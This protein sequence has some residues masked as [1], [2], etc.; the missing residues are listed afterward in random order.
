[1]WM[2]SPL[3]SLKM[4][5]T[6]RLRIATDILMKG[7]DEF[8]RKFDDIKPELDRRV[9]QEMKFQEIIGLQRVAEENQLLLIEARPLQSMEE[10]CAIEK[11]IAD[12]KA[13]IQ[14]LKRHESESC[15]RW[16]ALGEFDGA[17]VSMLQQIQALVSVLR[18][19]LNKKKSESMFVFSA[20]GM[21]GRLP[22]IYA[23]KGDRKCQQ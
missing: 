4:S 7:H 18:I 15:H 23:S 16:N 5:S 19:D 17:L 11:E 22:T 9:E 6:E 12:K 14:N 3:S 8:A 20:T 13:L 10:I 1:M 21:R 2:T